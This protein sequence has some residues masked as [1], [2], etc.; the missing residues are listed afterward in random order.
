[1]SSEDACSFAEP[2]QKSTESLPAEKKTVPHEN[3]V[4]GPASQATLG[5]KRSDKEN[6]RPPNG[7][8]VSVT[9]EVLRKTNAGS[10]APL[11]SKNEDRDDSLGELGDK[12]KAK[13]LVANTRPSGK[14]NAV[15][16]RQTLSQ[17]FLA[18]HA[19]QQQKLVAEVAKPPASVPPKALPG[20]YK[21]K[22]I[23]SKVN[24]FRK[25]AGGSE[26][27]EPMPA[28]TRS[29]RPHSRASK[30]QSV[31]GIGGKMPA[32]VPKLSVIKPSATQNSRSKAV[33][34]SG[35]APTTKHAPNAAA[36]RETSSRARLYSAPSHLARGRVLVPPARL[37]TEPKS[38][39]RPGSSKS[40]VTS[41][42]DTQLVSKPKSAKGVTGTEK[43]A[44]KPPVTSSLSQYRISMETAEQR[45]AR[46]AEWLASKGKTLK[47]PPIA[48]CLPQTASRPPPAKSFPKLE[49]VAKAG[50]NPETE[51]I[52][53]QDS[54]PEIQ[55][56][57]RLQSSPELDAKEAAPESVAEAAPESQAEA[58]PESQ[59]EA[60]PESQAEAAPES[61]AE[62]APESH[63]EAAPESHAEAA[64]ESQAEAA[65][66]SQAEVAPES[67]AEVAPES[68]EVAPS[69]TTF[70]SSNIMNTTLDLLENSEMDLPVDPEVRME[71]VVV[72]LCN[73]MEAMHGPSACENVSL[74][75]GDGEGGILEEQQLDSLAEM[76]KEEA[77]LE[78][79][80]EGIKEDENWNAECGKPT[81][82]GEAEGA[83]V[84]RYSVKTTPYLQSVKQRIQSEGTAPGSGGRRRSAIKDLK[85]LTPVRRS[86]RIQRESG[87]LPGML[88]DHDP[89][90]SSLAELVKLDDDANAYIYRRNLALL[91]ELPDQPEEL[92]QC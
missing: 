55:D 78:S 37:T 58:A 47:R 26:E 87:R 41:K 70:S 90:V 35:L 43:R 11:R 10:S 81:E 51:P 59:A 52:I 3:K 69:T 22:V 89:C 73:A 54:E 4:M 45:K 56:L 34:S 91:E 29:A 44:P 12:S 30:P 20:T 76:S 9:K 85:F 65:P 49:V 66:E 64:P 33:S 27:A 5:A 15:K 92:G 88:A 75:R 40:A 86:L 80:M 25:P 6:T 82:K 83:S 23:Q 7:R 32:V 24:S 39:V 8:N 31:A 67:V 36:P 38:A 79:E 18:R 42:K 61:H 60:A 62:A 68:A 19:I 77:D 50:N 84:V 28:Q 17:A 63:A 53:Q 2:R 1:M 21:G 71:D 57:E 14:G 72:N 74:D 13:P 48:S 16:K 46:L